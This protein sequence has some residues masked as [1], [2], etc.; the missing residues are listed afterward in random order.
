MAASPGSG[1]SRQRRAVSA[2]AY[3]GALDEAIAETKGIL[4]TFSALL[5]VAEVEGGARR[6][7][8]TV[9]DLNTVAAD[10]AEFYEPVAEGKGIS[11]SLVPA[12]TPAEI[13]GDPS[14]LFEA[15]GNLVDNAIKFTPPGGR[16]AMRTLA[17]GGRVGVEVSDTGPGIAETERAAV[18]R[19]FYR[20]EK[21]RHEQGSGLGL[22]LVAAVARLHGLQFAIEG[23]M[24]GCRVTLR[25]DVV[26][27]R[28]AGLRTHIA[29]GA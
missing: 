29:E 17:G 27:L 23:A 13:P 5:R 22:S 4:A 26:G 18:L 2:D 9:L 19:R 1:R 7:G 14:L 3:A 6:A 28:S 15:I 25:G 20:A 11:L 10:V 8:F 24:P 21:S 16:V 12:G